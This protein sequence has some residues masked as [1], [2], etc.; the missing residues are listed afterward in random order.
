ML[1]LP[2]SGN[3]KVS[4]HFLFIFRECLRFCFTQ[5]I[6]AELHRVARHWNTHKIRP[7]SHQETP[8]GKPDVLF[9]L[10]QLKGRYTWFKFPKYWLAVVEYR[11]TISGIRWNNLWR[12]FRKE[13]RNVPTAVSQPLAI[14]WLLRLWN[15][16]KC[17]QFCFQTIRNLILS[18]LS[19]VRCCR[20][21]LWL[22]LSNR[23]SHLAHIRVLYFKTT[24]IIYCHFT[25]T[26]RYPR[27]QDC[28][29][30]GRPWGRKTVV[31]QRSHSMG[32]YRWICRILYHADGREWYSYRTQHPWRSEG[33]LL[34][35]T[36]S[37]R[38]WTVNYKCLP[39]I[40]LCFSFW[41]IHWRS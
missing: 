4:M 30:Q 1:F 16:C 15:S 2:G 34:S 27:L 38:E 32:L 6:Q 41:G 37:G 7:Y 29:G 18:A 40:S 11:I 8:H 24:M 13:K 21:C 23:W 26:C 22:L 5:P 39:P 12:G 36:D 31:L 3:R 20:L 17:P 25:F 9:F 33:A 19:I 10:P 28:R 14:G 35:A